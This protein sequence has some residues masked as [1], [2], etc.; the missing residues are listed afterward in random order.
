MK[1]VIYTCLVGNYDDLKQPIVIDDSYD[2]ICFSNDFSEKNVGVWQIRRIPFEH[3]DKTRLSRY[4]KFFPNRV[5]ADYDY[6]VWMDCNLR[7]T[8][9]NFYKAVDLQINNDSLIAQVP[10]LLPPINCIYDEIKY[11]FKLVRVGFI[12]ARKQYRHLKQEGFPAHYGLFENNI[13]ARFHNDERVINISEEWWNE[14]MRY[15]NRDQFS[16]MYVYWKNHFMPTLLLGPNENS[17]NSKCVEYVP[18]IRILSKITPI[19]ILKSLKKN[20]IK[21]MKKLLNSF[22]VYFIR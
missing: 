6:S 2:Y 18:H 15:S 9:E 7:I 8:T 1:K 13:I 17:W 21:Q 5:L 10:H 20:S 16:L 22:L 4:V 3:P 14:Y 12:E 19:T 11:A